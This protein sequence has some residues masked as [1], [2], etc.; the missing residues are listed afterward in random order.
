MNYDIFSNIAPAMP[1]P[2]KGTEFCK[3][4]L[5][6][7]SKDNYDPFV[8]MFFPVLGAQESAG[9]APDSLYKL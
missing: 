6:Q 3:L 2:A 9:Q 1:K 7:A 4:L 5:S 8:P